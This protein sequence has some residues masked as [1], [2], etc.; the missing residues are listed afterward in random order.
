MITLVG[1]QSNPLDAYKS[2]LEL[3]Y[4]ALDAYGE[5]EKRCK[6]DKIKNQLK[7]MASDHQEHIRLWTELLEKRNE[8]APKG[9][10]MKRFL[11]QG[12]VYIADLI[13]DD[14]TIL[15][16]MLS[17]EEDTNKAYER[18]NNNTN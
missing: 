4:E 2:L 6:D 13:G 18:L 12:K 3:E 1:T 5:A 7:K 16:A 9:G 11:T 15:Q 10:S 8:T 14:H 17:N